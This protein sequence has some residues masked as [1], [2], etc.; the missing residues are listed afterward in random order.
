LA[1]RLRQFGF[2]GQIDQVEALMNQGAEHAAVE[3]KALFVSTVRSMTITDA[4]SLVTGGDTAATNYFRQ[5]TESE[6]RARYQ[7]IIKNNLQKIGF[8]KQYEQM[9]TAYKQLP[10]SN[11]PELDLEQHVLTQSLNALFA[12]VAEEEKAIRKDPIRRG[13][14]A[15][16]AVFAR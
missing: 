10:L 4:L 15:I 6:L 2:G 5:R 13:S 11:K 8:Y 3:A 16:A 7:P 9:L 14:S 1:S 12:Q